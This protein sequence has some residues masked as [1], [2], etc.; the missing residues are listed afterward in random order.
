VVE[1][2]TAV[3]FIG[4]GWATSGLSTIPQNK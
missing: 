4:G 2:V 1:E 3:L